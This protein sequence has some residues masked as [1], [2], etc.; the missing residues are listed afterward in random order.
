MTQSKLSLYNTATRQKEEFT[1]LRADKVNLYCCGPTVYNFAHIGNLR[2]YIF[3]DFLRRALEF[4]GYNVNHIV[5]ITDVGHLTS[6]EDTGEDKMEKGAVREGK[7]VWEIAEFYAEAFRT[8]WRK[9]QLLEPTRWVK[10]TDHIAEQIDLVRTLEAKGYTYVND[11]GVYFDTGKFPRY[12]DFARLDIQGL[13]AGARVDMVE[14][15]RQPTDFALWKFSPKDRQRAMEWDSPWGKGFPGW[16]VEC[17]AMA[18][19]HGGKTLDIHCGGTDHVRVHHTNEIAQ[20]ECATGSTFVRFWV[21]G[22][23]LR[24]QS[25]NATSKMSKSTGNFL[26]LGRLEENGFTPMDYRYFCMTAHYRN[27]LTFSWESLTS[28]KDSLRALRRRTDALIGK[29]VPLDSPMAFQWRERFAQAINDDLNLPQALA[30]V[31]RMLK[32]PDVVD[33]EKAQ[34][35]KEW[36]AV[37]GLGLTQPATQPPSMEEDLEAL[38][39]EREEARKN[40]D[41]QRADEIRDAFRA[42]GYILKDTP[43]GTRW[44]KA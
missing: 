2:T 41:F 22:E 32:D 44:E 26:T 5:N 10:A 29:A 18:L 43:E 36:E 1:P 27:F 25:D 40:K 37:L 33:A 20:S 12:G 24:L 19:K 6:D 8:D 21:H 38:M 3:E 28:A 17:S 30:V 16:H 23:F 9:L 4:Q 7:T 31:N 34:L 42:K 11:D 13:Q 15:K 39:L 35:I 14:G